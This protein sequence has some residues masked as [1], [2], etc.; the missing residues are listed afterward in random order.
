MRFN[1]KY[2]ILVAL[3]VVVASCKKDTKEAPKASFK[4]RLVYN[5]T[6]INVEQNQ[7]PVELYQ[8]GF[9][10]RGAIV[11]NVT[12]DGAFS[13]LLFNGDYKLIIPGV[14]GPFRWNQ[15]GA[16]RDSL[17]VNISGDKTMDLEVMP[18]YL[19]NDVKYS[20]SGRAVTAAFSVN[21]IITDAN[22]R[23]IERVTLYVNKT[24]FVS[25]NGDENVANNGIAGSAVTG[26]VNLTAT[27]P[28]LTPT[29]GY[30]FAR[31]GLKIA[32]VDD[33]IYSP[34]QKITL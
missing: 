16:T 8:S 26:T 28:T 3:T 18:Y 15:S 5:G 6:P 1:F 23:D 2:I 4:G 9:G 13:F 22:A 25:S 32:G 14:Q 24:Q 21:K 30:V 31:V 11:G 20:V 12:Q 29:Q 10:K 34:L 27:V 19:I 7:V 17:S 33:M